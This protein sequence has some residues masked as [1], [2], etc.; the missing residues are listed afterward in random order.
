M[1]IKLSK[2]CGFCFGVKRAVR[3]IE[4]LLRKTRKPV[5]CLGP[6]IHNPRVVEQFLQKGLKVV[7]SIRSVKEGPGNSFSRDFSGCN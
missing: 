7:S 2:H 1:K 4:E 6:F 3:L 5:Y